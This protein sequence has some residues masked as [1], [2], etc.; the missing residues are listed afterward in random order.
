M[1]LC[2]DCG[3]LFQE[4]FMYVEKHGEQ[5]MCCPYCKGDYVDTFRCDECGEWI[6]SDKYY[7]IGKRKYCDE[8]CMKISLE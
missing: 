4:P 1:Y 3:E 5:Q 6:C 8:C 7:I 2:L